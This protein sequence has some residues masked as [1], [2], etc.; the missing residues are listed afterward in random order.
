MVVC[1][2]YQEH[3]HQHQHRIH[4]GG[5]TISGIVK[6]QQLPKE[7][8]SSFAHYDVDLTYITSL[9]NICYA[10]IGIVRPSQTVHC[11]GRKN[12]MFAK[13]MSGTYLK[14]HTCVFVTSLKVHDVQVWHVWARDAGGGRLMRC[15]GEYNVHHHRANQQVALHL[16]MRRRKMNSRI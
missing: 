11:Q 3:R 5:R 2:T 15:A 4:Q 8:L 14:S 16:E 13:E 6:G 10:S 7:L 12:K 9:C 1:G